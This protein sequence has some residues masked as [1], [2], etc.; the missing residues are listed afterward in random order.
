MP[1]REILFNRSLGADIIAAVP[2]AKLMEQ[3]D[4]SRASLLWIL[5]N[6]KLSVNTSYL[7]I[8]FLVGCRR[9]ACQMWC[10]PLISRT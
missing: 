8:S 6:Q 7:P 1:D 10:P 2:L 3:R 9:R 4:Q 5:G